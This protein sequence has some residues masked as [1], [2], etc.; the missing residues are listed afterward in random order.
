MTI[1]FLEL[2]VRISPMTCT[3][4]FCYSCALCR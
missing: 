2:R 4:V 1:R 3:S